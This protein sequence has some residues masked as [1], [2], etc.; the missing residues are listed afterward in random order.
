[1]LTLNCGP[2]VI[3]I[4]SVRSNV[5]DTPEACW[6]LQ[7]ATFWKFLCVYAHVCLIFVCF[8]IIIIIISFINEFGCTCTQCGRHVCLGPMLLSFQKTD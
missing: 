2:R 4:V 1:M 3:S 6:Q 7:T 8:L 5:I